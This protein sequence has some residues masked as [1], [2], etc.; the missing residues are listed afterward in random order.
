LVIETSMF[1][2]VRIFAVALALA[3]AA[4]PVAAACADCCPRAD[5]PLALAAAADCCGDCA[6]TVDRSPER[7]SAALRAAKGGSA[8]PAG[9]SLPSIAPRHA[10]VPFFAIVSAD[11]RASVVS[12]PRTL[13]PL[14]L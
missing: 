6:E 4:G 3:L 14:R 5:A 9:A 8:P 2:R 7:P 11:A 12:P 10:P 13:S 1:R